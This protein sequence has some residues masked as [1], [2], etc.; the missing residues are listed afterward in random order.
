MPALLGSR[1]FGNSAETVMVFESK[2]TLDWAWKVEKAVAALVSEA[3]FA[4]GP[5]VVMD[6]PRCAKHEELLVEGE[7]D[8]SLR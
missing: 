3:L 5:G 4:E 7:E 8:G 1:R 6:E 2:T